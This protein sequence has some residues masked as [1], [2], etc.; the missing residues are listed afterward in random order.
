MVRW[1]CF[2]NTK[3][4]ESIYQVKPGKVREI[5]LTLKHISYFLNL[6][7]DKA[8]LFSK[9]QLICLYELEPRNVLTVQWSNFSYLFQ[10]WAYY[11]HFTSKENKI[12]TG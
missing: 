2:I 3:K 6:K 4:A 9:W 10:M 5:R 7:S 12:L 11:Y 1:I 8:Y